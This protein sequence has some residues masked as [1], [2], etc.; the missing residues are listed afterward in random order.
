MDVSGRSCREELWWRRTRSVFN[1]QVS[2]QGDKDAESTST[3]LARVAAFGAHL[4]RVRRGLLL[5]LVASVPLLV[6]YGAGLRDPFNTPK[7]ALLI[8][9]IVLVGGLRGAGIL[10]GERPTGLS[11][12]I[13]PVAAF[14]VP[15]S[16]AWFASPDRSF[17]L[18]GWDYGRYQ[19]L[20][21]YILAAMLGL[22]VADAFAGR[23]HQVVWAV[24]TAGFVV[25]VYTL[26]QFF[27]GD[28][29]PSGPGWTGSGRAIAS[30]GNPNFTGGFLAVALGAMVPLTVG[31]ATSSKVARVMTYVIAIALGRSFSQG[32]WIAGLGG[33]AIGLGIALAP[34]WDRAR[35]IGK[36]V[37]ITIAAGSITSVL[38]AM[39]GLDLA[40]LSTV[41]SRGLSWETSI[42]A[43]EAKPIFGHGLNS[44]GQ[45]QREYRSEEALADQM[46][47]GSVPDDPHALPLAMLVNAGLVTFLGL[48]AV[49]AWFFVKATKVPDGDRTGAALVGALTAYLIQ[50]LSSIDE[51]TL[52]TM[53]WVCL[54]GLAAHTA[55]AG[56]SAS[57][58]WRGRAFPFRLA[59]GSILIL[60][61]LLLSSSWA[62]RFIETHRT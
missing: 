33:V 16:F 54:G 9:G 58:P 4:P 53:F 60:A 5:G 22:L 23:A 34:R 39:G 50:S 52:R 46:R 2:G 45:V 8:F 14:L 38:V 11:R 47:R 28:F 25:G 37:A 7:L 40:V 12:L 17:A 30:L 21:P 42:N 51:V 32:A 62:Y 15:F 43:A 24:G 44:F 31:D 48:A 41:R 18:W 55:V 20:V 59:L 26:L 57:G 27:G 61:A 10:W 49:L 29:F 3:G 36:A 6:L 35:T 1:E 56:S 19:G 13:V